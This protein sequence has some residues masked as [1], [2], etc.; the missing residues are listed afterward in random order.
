LGVNPCSSFGI[1]PICNSI[2]ALI[3][4]FKNTLACTGCEQLSKKLLVFFVFLSS[5]M[6]IGP[7]FGQSRPEPGRVF[8]KTDTLYGE[9]IFSDWKS[10]PKRITFID[11]TR[12]AESAFTADEVIAFEMIRSGTRFSSKPVVV[13]QYLPHPVRLGQNPVTRQDTIKFF[14]EEIFA[15]P[16]MILSRFIGAKEDAHY[17]LEMQGNFIELLN[18]TFEVIKGA[19]TYRF[20]EKVFRTQLEEALHDIPDL[21]ASS[22]N[23]NDKSII[24]FLRKYHELKRVGYKLSSDANPTNEV[25]V[26][27]GFAIGQN[28]VG[29]QSYA[30]FAIGLQ[31]LFAK[32]FNNRFVYVEFGNTAGVYAGTYLGRGSLQA[33]IYSG[34][35]F[36]NGLF[37]TGVALAYNKRVVFTVHTGLLA[38]IDGTQNVAFGVRVFPKLGPR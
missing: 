1:R 7:L 16:L 30:T 11:T 8:T 9:I 15:S 28:T 38:A 10:S 36:G 3:M 23:Y 35:S 2:G 22:V 4:P 12:N 26:S 6:T 17:Y 21:K 19:R 32:K 37:D 33:A 14:V 20:N 27:P 13:R 25:K 29:S 18:P 24:T 31:I 34:I 5:S